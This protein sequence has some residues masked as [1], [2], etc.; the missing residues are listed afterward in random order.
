MYKYTRTLALVTSF[1]LSSNKLS[2]S[3][4]A[5]MTSLTGLIV[6]N[7]SDNC[8]SKGIPERIGNLV[9]LDTLDLSKN[10]LSGIIP[11]SL[12][13]IPRLGHLNLSYNNLSG[14][15]P[16]GF[17]LQTL[18]NPSIYYGNEGLCGF[19]LKNE[20]SGKKNT[21]N[22]ILSSRSVD[23]NDK[24]GIYASIV[25]G[26][27]VGFWVFWGSLMFKRSFRALYFQFVDHVVGRACVVVSENFGQLRS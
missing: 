2:G 8:L 3:I 10:Q 14:E 16:K 24:V 17:Q 13:S 27:I 20:C 26:F 19:P 9:N 22:T 1:D 6:L 7:L 5:E 4:P 15:I 25:A 12:A 11:S 23:R 21:S 18:D